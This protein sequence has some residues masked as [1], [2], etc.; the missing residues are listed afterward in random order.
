MPIIKGTKLSQEHKDSIRK[1]VG[2]G[3][4]NALWKGGSYPNK[5]LDCNKPIVRNAQRCNVCNNKGERSSNWKGGIT[6]EII[7]IRISS[8]H[9][10][11]SKSVME[12][13]NF[14][15]FSCGKRG[16]KL[17]AHHILSFI[18]FPHKR[19]DIKNGLTLC[20]DCHRKVHSKCQNRR[21][22]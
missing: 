2:F 16:G 19:F 20:I 11:W 3:S 13:D 8:E 10:L 7:L 22:Y 1:G 4:N 9:R 18:K 17:H 15:C 14:T 12:R 5:C 6:R 21:S